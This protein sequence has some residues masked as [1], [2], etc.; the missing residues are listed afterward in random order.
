MAVIVLNVIDTVDV[1]TVLELIVVCVVVV[2]I[3][4]VLV[5]VGVV[6]VLVK[7]VV[8]GV[9]VVETVVPVVPV[10]T[11]VVGNAVIIGTVVVLT[12]PKRNDPFPCV[13]VTE[14]AMEM[15]STIAKMTARNM[16]PPTYFV[17][18]R[19]KNCLVCKLINTQ[20]RAKNK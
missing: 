13:W 2:V 18:L 3:V 9:A 12:I 6:A 20:K 7:T 8:A 15:A 14:S 19:S 4:L 10:V 5:V 11:V 1:G 17:I 16:R